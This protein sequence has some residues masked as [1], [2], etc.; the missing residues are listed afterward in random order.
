MGDRPTAPGY[1]V[2]WPLAPKAR[3][4]AI[5]NGRTPSLTGARIGFIWD[6]LF[7]GPEIFDETKAQLARDVGEVTFVDYTEFGNF[8]DH[9]EEEKLASL[10]AL[11]QEHGVTAVVAAVGG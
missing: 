8:H 10:P 2:L 1:D 5:A 9:D 3:M 6:Y 4:G 11:L 7:C